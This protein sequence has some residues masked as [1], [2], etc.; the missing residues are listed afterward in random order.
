M[1]SAGTHLM[2]STGS[3]GCTNCQSQSEGLE[4]MKQKISSGRWA[5]SLSGD[6]GSA[7]WL[8]RAPQWEGWPTQGQ[9]DRGAMLLQGGP[10]SGFWG[11]W[12]SPEPW[13]HC[14]NPGMLLRRTSPFLPPPLFV[15]IFYLFS[16]FSKTFSL[17]VFS[18]PFSFLPFS[19]P[20]S[21]SPLISFPLLSLFSRL[22]SF[23]SLFVFLHFLCPDLFLLLFFLFLLLVS[24]FFFFFLFASPFS[25]SFHYPSLA[26]SN[27]G[28]AGPD[29]WAPCLTVNFNTPSWFDLHINLLMKIFVEKLM[30]SKAKWWAKITQILSRRSGVASQI[31]LMSKFR[32]G[33]WV[34]RKPVL[35]YWQC[36]RVTC[37]PKMKEKGCS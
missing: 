1:M 6:P 8:A 27:L 15:P 31:G 23:L 22:L 18:F 19:L 24:F 28:L 25:F 36:Y 26:G 20:S 35:A 14:W 16:I 21:S 9:P 13:C 33:V 7:S 12:M 5:P 29:D 2:P 11:Q 37:T 30:L 10:Q 17:P 32:M 3:Q 34:T 4:S